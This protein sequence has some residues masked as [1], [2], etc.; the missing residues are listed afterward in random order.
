MS[1]NFK[2]EHRKDLEFSSI[3]LVGDR[4]DERF[5][6]S[7]VEPNLLSSTKR[8]INVC[9]DVLPR[10]YHPELIK[11]ALETNAKVKIKDDP[12]QDLPISM[13][14]SMQIPKAYEIRMGTWE[15]SNNMPAYESVLAHEMGH[16][17]IEWPCQKYGIVSKDDRILSHWDRSI[18]EGVADFFA[19][20]VTGNTTIVAKD[21]WFHRSLYDFSSF[22]ESTYPKKNLYIQIRDGLKSIGL[23]PKYKAYSDWLLE[24]KEWIEVMGRDPYSQGTW[25][26]QQLWNISDSGKKLHETMGRLIEIALTGKELK[27]SEDLLSQFSI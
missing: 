18:Y 10:E 15:I 25:I 3:S 26:A 1:L 7:A 9:A 20:G 24:V 23:V 13:I 12:V 6:S 8:V 2:V 22:G 16:M 4:Q 19:A 17:L 27:N 11:I 21:L 14:L 5:I